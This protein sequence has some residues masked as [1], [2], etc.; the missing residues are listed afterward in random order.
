MVCPHCEKIMTVQRY[1]R[2]RADGSETEGAS[3]R[4][5]RCI[6]NKIKIQTPSEYSILK[7]IDVYFRDIKISDIEDVKIENKHPEYIK[8]LESIENKRSKFQRAWGNDLMTDEE[9]KTRM[10]ETRERYEELKKLADE[11]EEPL[12]VDPKKIKNI[13]IIK[14]KEISS[15]E[16][17]G[18]NLRMKKKLKKRRK[19]RKKVNKK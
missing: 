16:Q 14:K 8:E 2:K 15:K 4:C 3:Y 12:P 17:G 11:Y 7:A 6:R 1:Y 19:K 9:F 10:E 5:N 13:E 18:T